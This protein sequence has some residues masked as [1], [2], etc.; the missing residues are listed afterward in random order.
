[1]AHLTLII[2]SLLGLF[3]TA[4]LAL[5]QQRHWKSV[6]HADLSSASKSLIRNS[7]L[8]FLLLSLVVCIQ[9]D[10]A[11]FAALLWALIFAVASLITALVLS[12]QP[13]T[14]RFLASAYSALSGSSQNSR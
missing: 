13:R 11:G 12:Y 7:G 14:L 3:G 1:M 6:M 8:V 4:S 5:C 2:A 10:G 9:R